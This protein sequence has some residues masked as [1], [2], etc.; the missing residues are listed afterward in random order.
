MRPN[1]LLL[2]GLMLISIGISGILLV[3]RIGPTSGR[4]IN[5]ST[6]AGERIFRLG[7][8]T[9]GRAI[10]FSGGMMMPLSCAQC[11]GAD[12]R[13][14]RRPMFISPDITYRNLTDPAGMQEPDATVAQ[15]TRMTSSGALSPKEWMLKASLWPGRCRAGS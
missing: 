5:T 9:N 10:P 3:G 4:R 13:G 6:A 1:R 8:D 7:T 12:G 14:R 2:A 11:H 15:P